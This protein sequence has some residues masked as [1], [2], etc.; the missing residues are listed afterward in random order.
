MNYT[1][2]FPSSSLE[3][4]FEKSLLKIPQIKIREAIRRAVEH[5]ADNPRPYGH[6]SF[7]KLKPPIPYEQ[8]TAQYRLRIGDFRVLYDIDDKDKTVWILALR[9]RDN[10]TYRFLLI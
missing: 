6:K 7:K 3:H 10:R 9:K 4:E 5:L 2:L 1:C 8:Y